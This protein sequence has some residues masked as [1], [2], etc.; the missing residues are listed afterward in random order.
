MKLRYNSYYTNRKS[1]SF[2][3]AKKESGSGSSMIKSPV[4][5]ISAWPAFVQILTHHEPSPRATPGLPARVYT[6]PEPDSLE[7]IMGMVPAGGAQIE[8]AVL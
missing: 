5:K 4:A 2:V 8:A 6:F 3:G 1:R 7:E